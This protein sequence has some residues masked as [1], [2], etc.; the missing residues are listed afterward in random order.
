MDLDKAAKMGN[1]MLARYGLKN[2]RLSWH[3]GMVSFGLCVAKTKTIKLSKPLTLACSWYEVRDTLRHEIAHVFDTTTCK[4]KSSCR[5][6]HGAE[7]Q[8][9]AKWL[10]AKIDY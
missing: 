4:H 6:D 1:R 3:S 10:G 5:C 9:W 7:W 8:K 2:W